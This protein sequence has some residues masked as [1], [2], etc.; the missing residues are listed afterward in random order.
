MTDIRLDENLDLQVQNGD[1][2]IGET[3]K[4]NQQLII[5]ANK[6]EWKEHPEVGVGIQNILSD[7]NPND[8]L[9]ETK[10]QLEYDG[11]QIDNISLTA[12]GKLIIDGKYRAS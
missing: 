5:L 9:I 7:E 2:V 1:F 3:D 8:V 4:Q 6:G 12:E 10:R 11:M